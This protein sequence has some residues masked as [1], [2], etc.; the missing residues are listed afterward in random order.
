M[1]CR[2][3]ALLCDVSS[4][5]LVA[6]YACTALSAWYAWVALSPDAPASPPRYASLAFP[7]ILVA[8]VCTYGVCYGF[9]ALALTPPL[10]APNT[11]TDGHAR[12]LDGVA[13]AASAA[14][15]RAAAHAGATGGAGSLAA[16]MPPRR[17]AA[18][19]EDDDD[20]PRLAAV[21]ERDGASAL[22][23]ARERLS[24]AGVERFLRMPEFGDAPLALVSAAAFRCARGE[25]AGVASPAPLLTFA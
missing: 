7:S 20:T 24:R 18:D 4:R 3:C 9:L 10:D 14:R 16:T 2:A 15:M 21:D 12:R 5:G 8:V 23:A 6:W 1:R 17:A 13:L 22:L 19:D 11:V 25:S